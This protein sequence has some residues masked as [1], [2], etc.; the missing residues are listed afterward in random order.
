VKDDTEVTDADIAS[1]NLVIFGDPRSNRLLA[2]IADKLPVR[3]TADGI[4]FAGKRFSSGEHVPALIYPNPLNPRRYVVLNTGFTFARAGAGSNAQ[5]TPKLPDYAMLK[6][7]DD[8]VA[9]AGFFD[10][11]WRP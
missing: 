10:E 5:Q 3:W 11:E 1:H 6:T 2:R 4:E 9:M 8:S 7:S